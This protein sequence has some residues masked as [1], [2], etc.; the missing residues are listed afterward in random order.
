MGE[1][2]KK[3]I[4]CEIARMRGYINIIRTDLGT[5]KYMIFIIR[6][7]VARIPREKENSVLK[8]QN[9]IFPYFNSKS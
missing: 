8:L 3:D 9:N 6:L 1:Q 2:R 7:S 5:L 4:E